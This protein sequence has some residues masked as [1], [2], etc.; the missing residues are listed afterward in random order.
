MKIKLLPDDSIALCFSAPVSPEGN[1]LNPESMPKPK[2]SAREFETVLIRYWDHWT[3][4][5]GSALFYTTLSKQSG[6]ETYKLSNGPPVNLLKGTRLNFPRVNGP[7]GEGGSY[8]VSAQGVV[9]TCVDPEFDISKRQS[10]EAYFVPI[11]SFAATTSPEPI[12]LNVPAEYTGSATSPVFTI[13]GSKI[14]FL[15][16]ESYIQDE[17]APSRIFIVQTDEPTQVTKLFLSSEDDRDEEWDRWP[18]S[19]LW[20]ASGDAM[21]FIGEDEGHCKMWKASYLGATAGVDMVKSLPELLVA[22]GTVMSI[23]R[24]SDSPTESKIFYSAT[25]MIDSS[26]LATIDTNTGDINVLSSLTEHGSLLGIDQSQVI[27][28]Y[29]DSEDGAYKIHVWQVTPPNFNKDAKYPL[30]IFIHGGPQVAWLDQWSHR[31]CPALYAAQGYVVLIPN[32]C[33]PFPSPSYSK[34]L[35]FPSLSTANISLTPTTAQA[36]PPTAP[37]LQQT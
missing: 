18:T 3:K 29:C 1:L 25:S 4:P 16:C 13:D 20:S 12:K 24:Q 2:T 34:L 5:Y 31:W 28:F 27:D 17:F 23:S 26:I 14:A 15:K 11:S 8:D 36:A 35:P 33:V 30:A 19:L 6:K 10:Q 22:K 9:F 37:P 7:F 32:L 21:Y